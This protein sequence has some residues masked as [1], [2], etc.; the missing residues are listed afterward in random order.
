MILSFDV[1]IRNLAYCRVEGAQEGGRVVIRDWNVLDL[2]EASCMSMTSALD[3]VEDLLEGVTTVLIEKQVRQNPKMLRM[4]AM[5]EMYLHARSLWNTMCVLTFRLV[6]A[7]HRTG[8]VA[9]GRRTK[10]TSYLRYKER[11]QRSVEMADELTKGM[12]WNA[13]LLR[14]KKK[15][16]LADALCQAMLYVR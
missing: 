8:Q 15:D 12:P 14:H 7:Y 4:S 9:E 10:K 13:F 6:P 16:D 11:K 5:L 2:G 3:G 1:G